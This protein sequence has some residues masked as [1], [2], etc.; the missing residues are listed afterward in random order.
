MVVGLSE[1]AAVGSPSYSQAFCWKTQVASEVGFSQEEARLRRTP[2]GTR[3]SATLPGAQKQ[4]FA[5]SR[6]VTQR[7]R[8]QRVIEDAGL[9]G[10]D[11]IARVLLAPKGNITPGR[12]GYRS[13]ALGSPSSHRTG[14]DGTCCALVTSLFLTSVNTTPEPS[15]RSFP[16]N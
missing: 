13:L 12:E 10:R 1:L 8:G 11:P 9:G 2:Q 6:A 5:L 14:P 15:R 16:R 7:A 3:C 4:P